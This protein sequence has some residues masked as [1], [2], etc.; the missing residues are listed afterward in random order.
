M[1]AT[2]QNT[3]RNDQGITANYANTNNGNYE[4]VE[5]ISAL[6]ISRGTHEAGPATP[7]RTT[8]DTFKDSGFGGSE[9]FTT[10]EKGYKDFILFDGRNDHGANVLA[11]TESSSDGDIHGFSSQE[12]DDISLEMKDIA[13]YRGVGPYGTGYNQANYDL[14]LAYQ[15][16]TTNVDAIYEV[17]DNADAQLF[18]DHIALNNSF[19]NSITTW[20]S[21][22]QRHESLLYRTEHP[23]YPVRDFEVSQPLKKQ[24]RA[25]RVARTQ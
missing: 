6:D 8:P 2:S 21:T 13:S 1:S 17:A 15:H 11:D 4:V 12:D 14:Q 18:Y 16:L 20:V 10:P 25:N 24:R 23:T 7:A 3:G 19:T 22:A 5:G 9:G